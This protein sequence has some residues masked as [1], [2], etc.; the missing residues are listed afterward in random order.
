MRRKR[1][2]KNY[3][4]RRYINRH[5][6]PRVNETIKV[7]YHRNGNK[8]YEHS[9]VDGWRD[10]CWTEHYRDGTLKRQEEYSRGSLLCDIGWDED[11][12]QIFENYY[13]F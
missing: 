6:D 1:M 7:G 4:Y 8:K 3:E 11:G 13:R 12:T 2:T 9:Y 5:N 10:G